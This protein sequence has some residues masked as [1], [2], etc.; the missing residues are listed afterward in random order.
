[1]KTVKKIAIII[2]CLMVFLGITLV[3]G[4]LVYIFNINKSLEYDGNILLEANAKV[5]IFDTNNYSLTNFDESEKKVKL[6]EI[7]SYIPQSFISIEDKNFYKQKGINKK[8]MAKALLNN[9]KSMSAKEGASTISQQLVKNAYLSSDKTLNRKI[10]EIF[11]TLKM[12]KQFT[13]EEILETYLNVIYFGNN[14]YGLEQASKNYFNKQAKD[15]SLEE[16]AMLAGLIKS[17]K[18]YSPIYN[19]ENCTQRRNLVLKEM[20]KDKKITNEEYETA[21][22][23][24]IVLSKNLL[25]KNKAF[26][27]QATLEEASK[28]LNISEKEL[29]SKGYKVFT[30]FN[31]EDQQI[32]KNAINNSDYYHKNKY[33]NIADSCGI[34]LDNKTSGVTAFAGKSIYDVVNMV[35]SPGSSIKPI[36][37]YAPALENGIISPE[38][39]ILDEETSFSGYTPHNVG[40]KYYGWISARKTIEKS[41]NVPAIKIMQYTGIEKCKNF[42]KKAGITFESS[43][44]N[45]AIALGGFTKG[46]TVKQLVNSYTPLANN[47][48]YNEAH[49]VRKIC[50]KNG[51]L[52]YE[53]KLENN[54]IMSEETAYLLTDM[55]KSSTKTG[56]SS[57]LKDLDFDIAGKT[58]TVGLKGTNLNSD[59]WSVAYTSSKTCGVWLG[60]STNDKEF[61]LEGSNNG[62]TYPTSLIKEVF[63]NLGKSNKFEKFVRPKNVEE[64][65]IDS[66]ELE[67]NHILKLADKDSPEIFKEKVL[68]NSKYKPTLVGES[69]NELSIVKLNVKLGQ[70]KVDLKFNALP[71]CEYKIYRIEEDTVKLLD[72]IKNKK[73]E[74][75]YQDDTI[76]TDTSYEYYVEVNVKNY[77]DKKYEKKIKSNSVKV[78]SP[79]ILKNNTSII[80]R[81]FSFR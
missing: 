14:S 43:D 73:G 30:Y 51:V 76:E 42:A 65:E 52:V 32:L 80:N 63:V 6:S 81:N 62:G 29:A 50:D 47:G 55:L 69:F 8:R 16:S 68:F 21:V 72:T 49:F 74:I 48:V 78:Y 56:T 2:L 25:T 53:H 31:P 38:T 33:G 5:E 9:I 44:N 60:N 36:L 66:I 57:R 64:V 7:P 12:E 11:L 15:L 35:R 67:N 46:L 20:L 61:V 4:G 3:I 45:Y 26:Y 27:E 39:P 17:P 28:I 71:Q 59:I 77:A 37:V 18:L 13:K 41:L 79:S 24:E 54:K 23:K 1:M 58:G 19:L 34:I 22:N 10:K 75:K 70:N 40:N